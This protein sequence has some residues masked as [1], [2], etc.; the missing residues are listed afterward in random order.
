L[1]VVGCCGRWGAARGGVVLLWGARAG[2][3]VQRAVT[4]RKG[5]VAG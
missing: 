1:T 5:R 3:V 4:D 2:R